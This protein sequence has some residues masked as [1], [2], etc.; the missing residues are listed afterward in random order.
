VESAGGSA[1]AE[2][3]V[4]VGSKSWECRDP[5]FGF[6]EER[7]LEPGVLDDD[8][9]DVF[10]CGHC[11]SFAEA[12]R[13]LVARAELVF[14]HLLEDGE[15]RGHVLVRL[16]GRY[17]DVRGWIEDLDEFV[18]DPEPDRSF[19]RGWRRVEVI[20]PR[21]WMAISGDWLE[22]RVEDAMPFARTLLAR[23][24]VPEEIER[25]HT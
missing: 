24:G 16:D 10:T 2:V 7:N 17:L 21:D 15:V 11:H 14:A 8:A 6:R 4:V 20:E 9:V 22:P 19:E 23:L 25:R 1:T 18:D 12:L 3:P 13:R 5:F